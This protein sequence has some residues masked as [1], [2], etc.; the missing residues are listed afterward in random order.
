MS[1][2]GSGL[3]SDRGPHVC[4]AFLPKHHDALMLLSM[5]KYS[6]GEVGASL[7]SASG[8]GGEKPLSSA[9]QAALSGATSMQGQVA[10]APP[11]ADTAQHEA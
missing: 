5:Q 2:G 10:E 9:W 7:G 4:L 3:H 11:P 8:A 6:C 1:G